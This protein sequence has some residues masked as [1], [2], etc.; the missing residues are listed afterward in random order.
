MDKNKSKKKRMQ[1]MSSSNMNKNISKT[2][3]NLL[4]NPLLFVSMWGICFALLVY[5]IYFSNHHVPYGQ[6]GYVPRFLPSSSILTTF[7]IGPLFFLIYSLILKI[8]KK[9]HLSEITQ[10]MIELFSIILI[11][12]FLFGLSYFALFFLG[13]VQ[14]EVPGMHLEIDKH[15]K[16]DQIKPEQE[17]K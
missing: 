2:D 4:L 17:G 14:G 6:F 8:I 1:A 7:L 16:F 11:V 3:N 5:I 13:I 15:L 10:R 9:K 12:L